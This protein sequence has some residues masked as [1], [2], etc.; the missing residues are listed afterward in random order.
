MPLK[1]IMRLQKTKRLHRNNKI[2]MLKVNQADSFVRLINSYNE[3]PY[4]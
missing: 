4:Y 1:L 2:F 3:D